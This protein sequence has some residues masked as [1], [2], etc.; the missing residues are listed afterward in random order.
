MVGGGTS[1]SLTRGSTPRRHFP[2]GITN[3]SPAAII[4]RS[5]RRNIC[6]QAP[7]FHTRRSK[8]IFWTE[9]SWKMVF[10]KIKGYPLVVIPQSSSSVVF[11]WGGPLIFSTANVHSTAFVTDPASVLN[12]VRECKAAEVAAALH[13][14]MEVCSQRHFAYSHEARWVNP[15]A[16]ASPIRKHLITFTD[17]NQRDMSQSLLRSKSPAHSKQREAQLSRSKKPTLH[18]QNQCFLTYLLINMAN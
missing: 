7:P 9:S 17:S 14:K 4:L 13:F 15:A 10:I 1:R 12:Y 2:K 5:A 16:D 6:F 18:C 11:G 3:D 8:V